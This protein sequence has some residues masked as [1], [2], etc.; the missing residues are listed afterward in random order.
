VSGLGVFGMLIGA[1]MAWSGW[2]NYSILDVFK[3]TIT[4]GALPATGDHHGG[5]GLGHLVSFD[6]TNFFSNMIKGAVGGLPSG[7]IT[8]I[9][10]SPVSQTTPAGP[11]QVQGGSF[12]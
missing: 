11:G 4:G 12:V 10:F 8:G 5:A 7:P 6:W 1:A 3:R 2:H 9:P